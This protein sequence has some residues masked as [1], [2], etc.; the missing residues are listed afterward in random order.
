MSLRVAARLK[1]YGIGARVVDLRFVAPLPIA[2]IVRESV[3]TGRVLVADETRHSGGVG[4]GVV[5]ALVEAGFGG[6]I[7]RVSSVDSFIPL[8]DAAT[9]VLLDEAAIDR[10]ARNLIMRRPAPDGRRL[11]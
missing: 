9:T 6:P 3:A 4:E 2:D 11:G 8:G 1:E 7:T 10:A 5:T